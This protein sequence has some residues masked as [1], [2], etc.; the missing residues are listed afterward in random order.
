ML[1][2][3]TGRPIR[4]EIRKSLGPHL[5]ASSVPRRL[6]LLD[7]EVLVRR[8]DFERILIHEI[9]HFVWVRL[10]TP[11]R[12]G[13][14]KLLAAEIARGVPGEL[15]W[16]AE[17]RKAKLQSRV[18]PTARS[19]VRSVARSAARSGAWSRYVCESFCDSAGWLWGGLTRHEEFTLPASARRVRRAW[20]ER[21]FSTAAVRV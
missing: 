10:G 14:E 16:S 1:P 2:Q 4:V 7:A 8:G 9:F 21:E 3:L 17:W 15:G 11:R 6:I 18:R 19:G 5:A 12:R 20:L 13:W